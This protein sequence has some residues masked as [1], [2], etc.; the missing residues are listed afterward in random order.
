[1]NKQ[2][3]ILLSILTSLLTTA[4]VYLIKYNIKLKNIDKIEYCKTISD[5]KDFCISCELDDKEC[6]HKIELLR[7]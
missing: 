7:M 3:I 5:M 1:M 2:C 4:S 6:S